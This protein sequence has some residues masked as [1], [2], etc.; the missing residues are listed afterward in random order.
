MV[1]AIRKFRYYLEGYH[2]TVITDYSSL[3]WL[4]SL[5]N[6]TG[7]LARWAL[8]LVEYDFDIV[9][10]EGAM[11]HVLE[12]L[13]R[14]FENERVKKLSVLKPVEDE[15]YSRRR[16]DVINSPNKYRRPVDGD[17]IQLRNLGGGITTLRH[18]TTSHHEEDPWCARRM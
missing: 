16:E 1:W 15:W 6:P 7:R 18:D 14:M 3:K 17:N 4:H 11:H 10:R 2:F 5:R 9:H 8:D 13:P 12:A